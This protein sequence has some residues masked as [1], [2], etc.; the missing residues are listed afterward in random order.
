MLDWSK[1]VSADALRVKQSVQRLSHS[2]GLNG[3]KLHWDD[4]Q[5]VEYAI[6]QLQ[7]IMAEDKEQAA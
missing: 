2:L 5:N 1:E 4:R 7:K 3:A 6:D